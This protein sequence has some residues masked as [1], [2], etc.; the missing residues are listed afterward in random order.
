MEET[1]IYTIGFTKKNADTFF[2]LLKNNG[3][4]RLFDIRLNNV[5]QLAGFAKR[6][7][8][9]FFLQEICSVDYFHFPELAPTNEILKPYKKG[10]MSWRIFEKKFLELISIRRIERL[11]EKNDFNN[12]CLLC[13]EHEP[14][15]CHRRLVVEYLAENT[16][17]NIKIKHL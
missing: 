17:L 8:L 12:S 7:D 5:S 3:V 14:E 15:F 1:V 9:K 10:D 16:N 13:S 4:S 2:G 11:I 6:D